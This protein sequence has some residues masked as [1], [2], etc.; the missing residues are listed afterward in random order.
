VDDIDKIV[1]K[2]IQYT[3]D[4]LGRAPRHY[5]VAREG[6]ERMRDNLKIGAGDHEALRRLEDYLNELGRRFA[7]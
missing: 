5:P 7:N 6:L 3:E 2:A 4:I 1:D